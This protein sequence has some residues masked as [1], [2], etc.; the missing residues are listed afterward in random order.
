MERALE[1]RIWFKLIVCII[2]GLLRGGVLYEWHAWE[3]I[4]IAFYIP[5]TRSSV[6]GILM[7][8]IDIQHFF[9]GQFLAF[10][11]SIGCSLVC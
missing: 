7:T 2:G 6:W 3:A 9:L 1:G 4:W 10:G 5:T 11:V 8:A